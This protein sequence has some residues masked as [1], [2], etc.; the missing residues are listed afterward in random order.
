MYTGITSKEAILRECRDLVASSGLAAVSMRSVADRSHIA[1]GT[2]YNYFDNKDALL[3]AVVEEIWKDIFH[4]E[5]S[6]PGGQSFPE[7]VAY[8]FACVQKGAERYPGFF[9]AHSASLA[10]SEK[11]KDTMEHC[12]RHIKE[13]LLRALR[14]DHHVAA[15]AFSASFSPPEFIDFVMGHLLMLLVQGKPSCAMLIEIIRRT[16]Y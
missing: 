3:L 14:E 16:I 15:D 10:S 13:G 2:L 6:Y 1:L 9:P 8:L 12:F 11:A 4:M 5:D 7:Y